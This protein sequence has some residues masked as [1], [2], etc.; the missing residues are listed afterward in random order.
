MTK[1]FN[2]F[3]IFAEMR[4]GSNLLEASLN[5]FDGIQCHGEAFNP[6]LIGY[7]KKDDLLGITAQ[8]RDQNP[9][10]LI[11]TIKNK[12]NGIGGFRLFHNHD[13][14]AA[15][16]CLTD[17][18]CAKIIL[19]RNPVESYVSWKIA[20]E[21]DQWKLTNHSK[22][23]S[24]QISFD[25]V[26]FEK[27]LA[28]QRNFRARIQ[29]QLQ[30]S[31]QT[32]FYVSYTDLQNPE[33]I[34][35]IA[36]FLGV[37]S[38]QEQI[39]TNIKKQ[40]PGHLSEKVLNFDEMEQALAR[41]DFFELSELPGYEPSRGANV[42]SCVTTDEP[43]LLYMPLRGIDHAPI[44]NMM[45]QNCPD[46]PLAQGYNQKTLRE[47][48]KDHPG[49]IS[50][51]VVSHPVERAHATFCRHILNIGP[52]TFTETRD[53][54]RRQFD[55]PIPVGA[56]GTGWDIDQHRTAFIAFMDFVHNNLTG[57]TAL[58]AENTWAS[59][60]SLLEG[61]SSFAF[62]DHILRSNRL[63]EGMNV[64]FGT[65][66]N[67]AIHTEAD[68][69]FSLADVYNGKVESAVKA[70]YKKDYINFGFPRWDRWNEQA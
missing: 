47:W 22:R 39:Q 19:S 16:H 10:R 2:Y 64:I 54:L 7:P 46:L 13:M 41:S 32:G 25:A 3:V 70:C 50:F 23:K 62:P 26:E 36:R 4:T 59:Q 28:A 27:M 66:E 38:Q 37:D 12:S 63:S 5:S 9:I 57:Q 61:I 56:P 69:P 30:I 33:I 67:T 42:P 40:N 14:R 44:E 11:R 53:L 60:T 35:G 52:D 29:Q 24:A 15:D 45:A 48:K 51:T 21:T 31:G 49:H 55:L 58:H 17:P 43:A 1:A 6:A 18:A 34:N 68:Q 20:R 65:A 8:E